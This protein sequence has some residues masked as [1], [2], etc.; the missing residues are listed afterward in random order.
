MKEKSDDPPV[1]K[2]LRREPD[3]PLILQESPVAKNDERG[4]ATLHLFFADEHVN[5]QRLFTE[6]NLGH[7]AA[8]VIGGKIVIAHTIRAVILDGKNQIP[9]CGKS[10]CE[11][12]FMEL[13]GN[14]MAK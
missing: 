10:A 12:L 8:I 6:E 4:K 1:N 9:W 11:Y 7:P 2:I 14:A 3:V 13:N 5:T